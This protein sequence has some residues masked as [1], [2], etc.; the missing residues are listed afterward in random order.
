M[1]LSDNEHYF[2]GDG[3]LEPSLEYILVSW[4]LWELGYWGWSLDIGGGVWIIAPEL[5]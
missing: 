4:I 1:K 3:T 5:G 2:A